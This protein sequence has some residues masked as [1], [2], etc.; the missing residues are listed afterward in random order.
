M[1]KTGKNLFSKRWAETSVQFDSGV[2]FVGKTEL[3]KSFFIGFQGKTL[4]KFLLMNLNA[5]EP[6]KF[7][8]TDV[9]RM[10][11]L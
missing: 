5:G 1:K 6:F 8:R 9:L 3:F 4:Q 2:R 7:S 11:N 10:W